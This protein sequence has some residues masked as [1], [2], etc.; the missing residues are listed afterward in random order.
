[1]TNCTIAY[2]TAQT[3]GGGFTDYFGVATIS[4]CIL[5]GNKAPSQS[6]V[7][8]DTANATIYGVPTIVYARYSDIQNG[9]LATGITDLGNN[10][11]ADPL[12]DPRGIESNGGFAQTVALLPDSPCFGAG[13]SGLAPPTDE[14]GVSRPS[15]PSIGAYDGSPLTQVPTPT[16]YAKWIQYHRKSDGEPC[17]MR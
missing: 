4:N 17:P 1:M 2:N 12:L 10:I 15:L 7:Y 9:I 3:L 5:F 8:I 14:R 16:I 6:E 11:M 13:T